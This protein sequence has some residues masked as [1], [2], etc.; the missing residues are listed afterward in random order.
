MG[1]PQYWDSLWKLVIIVFVV[2]LL[3]DLSVS[4]FVF[5]CERIREFQI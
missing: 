2:L 5:L 1:N 4:I 3:M